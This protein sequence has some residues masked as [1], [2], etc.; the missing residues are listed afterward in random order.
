MGEIMG[1]IAAVMDGLG[2][3]Y[4]YEEFAGEVSG[5][6]WVG[7]YQETEPTTE[8]GK[9]E[10][11]FVITGTTGGTWIELQRAADSIRAEF[12]EIGGMTGVT[13][14]GTGYAIW[15]ASATTVPTDTAELKRIEITLNV[16]YWR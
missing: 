5:P 14:K 15:Y 10:A 2:L 4:D 16:K 7:H 1:I 6:Y 8:D 11:S 3:A 13:D 9:H 12:P